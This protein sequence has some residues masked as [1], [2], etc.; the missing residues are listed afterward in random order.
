MKKTGSSTRQIHLYI[1]DLAQHGRNCHHRH[2][3]H[4]SVFAAFVQHFLCVIIIVIIYIKALTMAIVK[5]FHYPAFAFQ[6]TYLQRENI[7]NR[8]TEKERGTEK[9]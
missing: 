4:P 8:Q 6:R 5:V 2:H 7:S 9:H 1:P 3:H